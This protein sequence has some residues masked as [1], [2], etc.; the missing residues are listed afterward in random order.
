MT[1]RSAQASPEALGMM[2]R[3][4]S[5]HIV[6]AVV[7]VRLLSSVIVLEVTVC[8]ASVKPLSSANCNPTDK[9]GKSRYD[10]GME[11]CSSM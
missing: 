7:L 4:Y 9:V 2:F 10:W 1:P 3:T 6:L 5:V 8:S 11:Y